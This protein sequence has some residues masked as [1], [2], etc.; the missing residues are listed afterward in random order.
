MRNNPCTKRLSFY[1]LQTSVILNL[2]VLNGRREE[3]RE[4]KIK[5]G[6]K[7]GKEEG[8]YKNS[9]QIQILD[10]IYDVS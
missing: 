8:V 7:G 1:I 5:G 2:S 6:R 3:G 9:R 4:E 10:T